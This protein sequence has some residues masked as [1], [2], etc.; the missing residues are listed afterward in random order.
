MNDAS[1]GFWRDRR[2]GSLWAVVTASNGNVV[3]CCGPLRPSQAKP[4]LL[5]YLRYG[6]RD[7]DWIERNR[8]EF[9]LVGAQAC[10]HAS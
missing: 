6:R 7:V 2:T 5:P 4:A 9:V 1:W 8:G 10:A 3:A